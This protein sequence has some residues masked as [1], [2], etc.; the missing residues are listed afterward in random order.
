MKVLTRDV[1]RF[2]ANRVAQ[3]L[4]LLELTEWGAA[5]LHDPTR[6]F[7]AAHDNRTAGVE[8]VTSDTRSGGISLAG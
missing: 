2:T 8:V 4:R 1:N 6:I 3:K 7:P 5:L